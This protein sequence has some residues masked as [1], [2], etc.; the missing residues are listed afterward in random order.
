MGATELVEQGG[1][2]DD[3]ADG[4][5][6]LHDNFELLVVVDAAEAFENIGEAEFLEFAIIGFRPVSVEFSE[7]IGGVPAVVGVPENTA[8]G[9][10]AGKFSGT[11]QIIVERIARL[12]VEHIG[13]GCGR[14]RQHHDV[15]HV[16]CLLQ[17]RFW[18]CFFVLFHHS[19]QHST[20]AKLQQAAKYDISVTGCI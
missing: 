11:F 3:E 2:T 4:G 14:E 16:A 9:T 6:A 5:D 15:H 20:R 19:S 13:A 7:L 18:F 10:N 12:G 17:H 1:E 8:G